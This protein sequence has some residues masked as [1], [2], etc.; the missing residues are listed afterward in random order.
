MKT[1]RLRQILIASIVLAGPVVIAQPPRRIGMKGQTC[2]ASSAGGTSARKATA[3]ARSPACPAIRSSTTPAPRRAASSRP[4]TA[5]STGSRSSTTS[6]CSRSARSR[7]RRPIRTSSGPGTGEACI[8]SHISVGEGIFKSTDAGKTWTR[9]GLE[10]T[11][12]IGRIV[13]DPAEPGHR[14]RVRARPRLRAAAGARRVPHHRR[15]QDLGARAVRR[16]EH[17]LLGHRDGSDEPAHALRRHVAARD[18]HLGPRERRPGQRPVHVA[19]RRRR[20]GRG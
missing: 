8:R 4:P 6:R 10:Q 18:P 13:I 20:P 11:G 14:A 5:A 2:S 3:S 19:R 15:R 16:R 1:F 7:S 9:M 12:R 17:R